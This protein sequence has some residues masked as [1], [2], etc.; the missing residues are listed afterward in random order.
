MAY[1]SLM[2]HSSQSTIFIFFEKLVGVEKPL[3]L[4]LQDLRIKYKKNRMNENNE[5]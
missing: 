3:T 5:L 4:F 2:S 1:D